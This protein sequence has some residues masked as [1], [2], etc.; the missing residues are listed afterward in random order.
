MKRSICF[1]ANVEFSVKAFLVDHFRAM[2]PIYDITVVTNTYNVD[3]L[4]KAGLE[5]NVIPVLLERRIC[6]DR[7][8]SAL[9]T[10]YRLFKN[11][12][13]DAIHSIT[14]KS[15]LLSMIAGFMARVPVR[16]HTFTGQVWATRRGTKRAILKMADQ[17]TSLCATHVLVD[18][19]S[20]REFLIREKVV[21]RSLSYVIANGSMCGVDIERFAPY[22]A[23]RW[24]TR[25]IHNIP[26]NDFVFLFLGRLTYD[27]GLIDLARAFND[28]CKTY[29][30][31][32]LV[33]VGPD[34]EKMKPE[35]F[36]I[37]S[38][39]ENK[40]HSIEY[41]ERPESYMAA[42]DVLCLPSYREGFGS[43]V[44][45]AASA[46]IPSIGT[47]IYGLTDAIE[48][49]RTGFLYEPGDIAELRKRMSDFVE[50]RDLLKEMAIKARSRAINDFSKGLV[51]AGMLEFYAKF[52]SQSTVSDK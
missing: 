7:D 1:I 43:V 49:G 52:W 23:A 48:D 21:S 6:L 42:S 26:D 8:I 31:I 45:E 18:S 33:I 25:K 17:I 19:H 20:Q 34:E 36:S 24:E 40:V 11:R 46:G 35:V 41:T 4:K 29:P 16:I 2:L 32:H 50:N 39:Y 15:G 37:C 14:P 10:L 30:D 13:F 38:L 28:L 12:R 3:F 22:P 51:V 44:I 27:K 5:I 47:R 9:F